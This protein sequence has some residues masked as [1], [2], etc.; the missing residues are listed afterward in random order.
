MSNSNS[1]LPIGIFDSGL[2]GLSILSEIQKRLPNEALIYLADSKNAPYG[3]KL[4]QE[5]QALSIINAD[6]LLSKYC[7][8]IVVACN[9]ATTNAIDVLRSKY[10]VPFIGIEPAIKP[11]AL[12]SQTNQ[13]GIL[14]TKGT[15]SSDLFSKTSK[16]FS[17]KTKIIEV[18]GKGIVEAIERNSTQ[19][20]D[21]QNNLIKQLKPFLDAEID[22]LV[23]GCSHF[24]F[25]LPNLKRIFDSN[26]KIIDSGF[27]V[28]K[29]TEKVLI[30]KGLIRS[31][32]EIHSN[33]IQLFTNGTSQE[34][35]KP[36]LQQL[37]LNNVVIH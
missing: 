13:I 27:A 24:P 32:T 18:E 35:L 14:A 37:N 6:F 15:L 5:I 11:A 33:P 19:T 4:K 17:D 10:D 21:F 36:L 1:N 25:I 31:Q 34:A 23:L 30:D 28:A 29:Q 12:E 20:E 26:V 22:H 16:R 2:G 3:E 8:L 9:T 7:K